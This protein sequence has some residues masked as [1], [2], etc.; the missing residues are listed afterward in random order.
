MPSDRDAPAPDRLNALLQ[1]EL[2][3]SPPEPGFDRVTRLTTRLLQAP[4]AIIALVDRDRQ[5]FKSSV[6]L[7]EPWAS[8][9]ET[10]LSHSFCQH[11]V[12]SAEPLV[13]S[14]AK[15]HPL[16]KDN[17]AIPS[18]GVNAYLGVP[19]KLPSGEVIGALCAID[20][21]PRPWSEDDITQI[22]E[23]SEIVMDEIA[24]RTENARR[25]S[26]E[27]HQ[28]VLV[29]EL[30]HR[31]KN[32]LALVD[33][34][35]ALSI[36]AAPALT[37]FGEVLRGRIAA[38]TRSHAL[39]LD[40]GRE[41]IALDALVCAELAPLQSDRVTVDGPAVQLSPGIA[42]YLSMGLHELVTNAVKYGALSNE[43][44]RVALS[45]THLDDRLRLAWQESDG[46]E[47]T[48]PAR[49]GFGS[50]LFER[51]LGAALKGQVTRDFAADGLKVTFDLP[52]S[53]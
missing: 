8:L 48:P 29:H 16:V 47:V 14:D 7:C 38:L 37:D 45:W 26:I 22:T 30:N 2:L 46:P 25:R 35:I 3:D 41:A 40:R 51:I 20:H 17:L 12:T 9:R 24:L 18:L 6:G 43:A 13:V 5:F 10:P 23:L 50:L 52:V 28:R 53:V 42:L 34:V 33:S 15:Q 11:V 32:T 31:V 44:G 1:T 36:R 21:E 19:L 27:Q 49:N 39:A 4:A